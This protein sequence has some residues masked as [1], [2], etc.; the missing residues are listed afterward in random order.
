MEPHL[1]ASTFPQRERPA[2]RLTLCCVVDESPRL[3]VELV[4]WTICAKRCLPE[5]RYRIVVYHVGDVPR[6][7][8]EWVEARGIESR[9]VAAAVLEGA[10]YCNKIAPFFDA[11]ATPYTIV[12]DSD[13]YFVDDPGV[14]LNSDRFRA[15]PNN[16][17][18]PPASVF[19]TLLPKS[20]VG[21]SYRPG[22]GLFPSQDGSRETH[23]N[24][25]NG[26]F[27]A[28]PERRREVFPSLW[29]K[30]AQW[31]VQNRGLL[32]AWGV[33]V[34]QVAF[35]LAME[36]LGE[37]VEFLPPQM[38]AV[39]QILTE[40]STVYAFHLSSAHVPQF[41]GRF[42]A[43]R[44]LTTDGLSQDVAAAV[45][46]LNLCI[47]EAVGV[48]SSLPSTRDHLRLFLNPQWERE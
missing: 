34:Y 1:S 40:I 25:I 33:H 3:H 21:R 35:A 43:D 4:L 9:H 11:H 32:G 16:H 42:N 48:I 22:L 7:I 28:V 13:L 6:D 2:E 39:L 17:C 30:W 27:I 46:R 18:R 23:I 12:C 29:R 10:P 15:P 45:A 36:E 19:K 20:G 41:P 47:G 44:T 26:G 8:I 14:F 24:N 38:N 5:T 37:D 31:L